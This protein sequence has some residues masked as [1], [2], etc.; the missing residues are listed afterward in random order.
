MKYVIVGGSGFVMSHLIRALLK[1]YST[2]DIYNIDINDNDEFKDNPNYNHIPVDVCLDQA[3]KGLPRGIDVVI[4][5]LNNKDSLVNYE[6]TIKALEYAR[7]NECRFIQIGDYVEYGESLDE[8]GS[9]ETDL[10]MPVPGVGVSFEPK[11]L[12]LMSSEQ[13]WEIDLDNSEKFKALKSWVAG[14]AGYFIGAET[15]GRCGQHHTVL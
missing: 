11:I 8:D 14:I 12:N 2:A 9:K 1:K 3:W 5:G 13:L 7:K 4:N 6:G 10:S 15:R